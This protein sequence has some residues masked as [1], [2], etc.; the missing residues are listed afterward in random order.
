MF[1]NRPEKPLTDAEKLDYIY[2]TLRRQSRT[3][4]IIWTAM[5]LVTFYSYYIILNTQLA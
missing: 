1:G 3:K 5:A 4:I 2:R